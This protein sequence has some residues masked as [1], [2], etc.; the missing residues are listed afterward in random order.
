MI[1][2]FSIDTYLP[3]FSGIQASLKAT[4]AAMQQT[5]SAFLLGF[6]VMSL[7]HGAL[8]DSFGR[9]PVVLWGLGV[10]AF[11]S[12]GCALSP[13]V[14]WLIAFR[15]LQG[16]SA[17]CGMVIS[18]AIVSDM[19]AAGEAQKVMT[20]VTIFF[21]LAPAIAPI[22]GGELYLHF[23]WEAVFWFLGTVGAVLWII[24][25]RWLPETLHRNARQSFHPGNL[26]AGYARLLANPRFMALSLASGI[27]FNGLFLY[28]LC[29]PA[30]LGEILHLPPDRYYI[31]FC[32]TISGMM[33]GSFL[34]GRLAGKLDRVTQVR[35]GFYLML[36]AGVWNVTYNVFWHPTSVLAILPVGLFAFGWAISVA[37]VT[38]MVLD[39]APQRRGVAS[40][41]HTAVGSI[42]NALVAGVVAPFVMHSAVALS[43]TSLAMALSGMMAWT[44]VNRRA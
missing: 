22:V 31:F 2:P 8:A 29:A 28:V 12:F 5:L 3:A 23:G 43:V 10:F 37:I 44:L 18:R 16:S 13:S 33:L 42:A 24:D 27:P 7:F 20:Q 17:A 34:S 35:R 21:G 26:A 38:L 4:P 19:F 15:A 6:G 41:L 25:W 9:R 36:I 30:F 32:I 11:S 39:L 40:S 1:G 14:G